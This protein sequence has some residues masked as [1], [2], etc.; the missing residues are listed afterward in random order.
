[1]IEQGLIRSVQTTPLGSLLAADAALAATSLTVESILDFNEAGG[2]L[3]LNTVTYVYT[4]ADYTTNVVTLATGLTGAAITG[5][6]VALS[7][8]SVETTALVEMTGADEPVP[9]R[10]PHALA[11]R[12]PE[13]IRGDGEQEAVQLG[14]V[15]GEFILTDV[16]GK[17][18]VIDG[19][20]IDET[21]LPPNPTDGLP[22]SSSPVLTAQGNIGAVHYRWTPVVNADAVRFNLYISTTPGF[23]PGP[24]NLVA[25]TAGSS[26]TYIP[27]P[28]DYTAT[29]Y[30][31]LIESDD[32]GD[33]APSAEVSAQLRQADDQ[34]ISATYAYLGQVLVDQLTG[35]S[36]NADVLLASAIRTADAGARRTIDSTGDVWYNS[37]GDPTIVLPVD[38]TAQ[39]KGD[40]ELGGLTVTGGAAF[41]G[42]MNEISRGA[43]FTL[44]EATSAP[45]AAPSAVINW[46]S[47]TLT[48]NFGY[49]LHWTGTQWAKAHDSATPAVYLYP[50]GGGSVASTIDLGNSND[51][52]PYGGLTRIGTSWY[53]LGKKESN[54]LNYITKYSSTGTLQTQV[55]V[56][57]ETDGN[58]FGYAAAIGTD[59][60]N[61]LTARFDTP[62]TRFVIETRDPTTLALSSTLNTASNAGFVG[63][64]TGVA[65]GSFDFGSTRNVILSKNSPNYYAFDA[66]GVYVDAW[67][68]PAVGLNG[69]A[70]DGTRFN[71]A[72]YQSGNS[73]IYKHTTV[74][75]T[76]ESALW[77][78]GATWRDTDATGGTHE[79]DLSPKSSFTMKK[80]ARITMTSAT[81]PDNGG[82]DDPNAVSFYIG[83]GATEPARTAMWRQILPGDGVNSL[84]AGD[85]ITFTGTNPPATNNF[86][87]ATPGQFKSSK[88]DGSGN[89]HLLIE[90]DGDITRG[91]DTAMLLTQIQSAACT[92]GAT[93]TTTEQDVTGATVT[94]T[95][96]R[97]NARYVCTGVFY[98]GANTGGGSVASGK[99]NVDGTTVNNLYAQFTGATTLDRATVTQT[100]SG[101][102]ASA[103]SHTL[104]L[105]HQITTN[106][107]GTFT[108]NNGQTT[109][110]VQIFE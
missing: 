72:K 38:G 89:P 110:T 41:R 22:P 9:A 59:G 33:A 50:S 67:T 1:M 56:L 84:I 78:V 103:G 100:W 61:V 7:P 24:G 23:T 74:N 58:L 12:V 43:A 108:L 57:Y 55:Q 54:G 17:V 93:T 10:V 97:P 63:P 20:Y 48:T 99:L 109:I 13:G 3:V 83:R 77:W 62:N 86:P 73:K 44:Q 79:S 21:T 71:G 66:A 36:L 80:R 27:S 104:K 60:T 91:P 34:D 106:V 40:A 11:D 70:W 96:L 47:I 95:T 68:V 25:T 16:I 42:S 37:A 31:Q 98:F 28:L 30:A 52:R 39:F 75:W 14:W 101:T 65:R 92:A 81:I 19:S 35:G 6:Q 32:D 45:Q 8:T 107:S 5:D 49:G 88:V 51:P 69:F 26:F 53:T 46:D 18:P 29:Y 2:S 76:T 4:A 64:V 94:F 85:F 105:R 15:D 82:T 87:G 90:G 102:L